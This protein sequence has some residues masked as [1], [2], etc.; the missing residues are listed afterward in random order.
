MRRALHQVVFA[1]SLLVSATAFAQSPDPLVETLDP[2][3]LPPAWESLLS[4][5]RSVDTVQADFEERRFFRFRA[6][7]LTLR[8]TLRLERGRGLSLQYTHPETYI[9]IVDARGVLV[10]DEHG[11][12]RAAPAHAAEST[13]HLLKAL[14]LDLAALGQEFLIRGRLET[15]SWSLS[16]EPHASSGMN[17]EFGGTDHLVRH[18]SLYPTPGRRI[19][20]TL[21]N[22]VSGSTFSADELE[23]FFR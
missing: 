17:I 19:D 7:P 13:A 21:R 3:Q 2:A 14:E 23:R 8:G 16:L 20:I 11:R 22:I 18:L 9:V 10:R 6:R 5:L 12:E 1:L 4:G 15:P